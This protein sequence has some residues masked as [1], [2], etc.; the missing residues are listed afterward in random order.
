MFSFLVR[1]RR[2]SLVMRARLN[3]GI[4]LICLR[5]STN[6]LLSWFR[7]LSWG[8]VL[9]WPGILFVDEQVVR[10]NR[11]CVWNDMLRMMLLISRR[12]RLR[13]SH[14]LWPLSCWLS[15]LVNLSLFWWVNSLLGLLSVSL[16]FGISRW[17]LIWF[18]SLIEIPVCLSL[19]WFMRVELT[20][21]ATGLH[22]PQLV[23]LMMNTWW[24][25]LSEVFFAS[26]YIKTRCNAAS[27]VP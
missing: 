11:R 26:F 8:W 22:D 21:T 14:L 24:R 23:L 18:N 15:N 12:V 2:L 3:D 25:V 4:M 5:F 9:L 16:N 17:Y 27:L 10:W 13:T 19:T 20:G 7:S 6:L 1:G